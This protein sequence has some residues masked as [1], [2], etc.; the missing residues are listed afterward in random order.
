MTGQ[1]HAKDARG[2]RDERPDARALVLVARGHLLDVRLGRRR[3]RERE[4]RPFNGG[5]GHGLGLECRQR[6]LEDLAG[7]VQDE[8]ADRVPIGWWARVAAAVKRCGDA[9]ASLGLDD[10]RV[11]GI[12][13]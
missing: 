12:D 13:V 8:A 9:G 4:L 6:F 10:L 1:S 7:P 5:C 11:H 3:R 2:A